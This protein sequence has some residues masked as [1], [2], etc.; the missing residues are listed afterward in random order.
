MARAALPCRNTC[1]MP[2]AYCSSAVGS[3]L[4]IASSITSDMGTRYSALMV[5]GYMRRS[6]T[7]SALRTPGLPG[8]PGA[9]T[10]GSVGGTRPLRHATR[11]AALRRS[12]GLI[13]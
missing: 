6:A 11:I 5:C 10:S 2:D 12:A 4:A 9:L 8:M 3:P 13:G 7:G 1:A